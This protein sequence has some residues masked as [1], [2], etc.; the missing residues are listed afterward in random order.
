MD[1]PAEFQRVQLRTLLIRDLLVS[2][3]P[4][5]NNHKPGSRFLF[6]RSINHITYSLLEKYGYDKIIATLFNS[7]T[8]EFQ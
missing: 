6:A 4:I 3:K 2:F 1:I 8:I 5:V 7:P